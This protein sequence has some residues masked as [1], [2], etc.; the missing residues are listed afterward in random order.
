MLPTIS[1]LSCGIPRSVAADFRFG[2]RPA[3]AI[4]EVAQLRFLCRYPRTS[5]HIRTHPMAARRQKRPEKA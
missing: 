5:T 3:T 4:P 2:N 1:M